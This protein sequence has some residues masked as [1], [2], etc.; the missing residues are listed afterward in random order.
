MKYFLQQAQ[1]PE[2]HFQTGKTT[3]QKGQIRIHPILSQGAYT[4]PKD[5][6]IS[7]FLFLGIDL[8]TGVDLQI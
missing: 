7:L 6:G 4:K 5:F 8:V 3:F 1:N 2:E